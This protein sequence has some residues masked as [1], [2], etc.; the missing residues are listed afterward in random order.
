[1]TSSEE[2]NRIIYTLP[3]SGE[4]PGIDHSNTKNAKDREGLSSVR[5]DLRLHQN[6]LRLHQFQLR[7]INHER[8]QIAQQNDHE[9]NSK[10]IYVEE[11]PW[12]AGDCVNCCVDWCDCCANCCCCCG[13]ICFPL[14]VTFVTV[15][16]LYV[17]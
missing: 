10:E 8:A 4:A 16:V 13:C 6:D 3:S 2:S 14:F 5:N 1:M 17:F 15:I 7:V 9:Q 11:D 12:S